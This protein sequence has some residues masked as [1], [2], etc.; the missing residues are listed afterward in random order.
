MLSDQQSHDTVD[1]RAIDVH[2]F[3]EALEEIRRTAQEE[4]SYE[5]YLHLRKIER[6]GRF[7][8]ALGVVTC[9]I[10]PNPLTAFAF[11]LGQF[12]RWLLAHHITHKGYDKVPG[13]PK[14][15]TAKHFARGWRRFVD[16]FDWLHPEAWDY[17]HNILH[18]YHT[19]EAADPDLAERHAEFLRQLKLPYSL[20]YVLLGLASLT[21]KYTYYAPN[22]LSVLDP[23]T[24]RRIA[25]DHVLY[26]TIRN[27]FQFRNR[28]VRRLWL[29]CYL[30]YAGFHFVLFPL[31]FLPFGYFAVMSAFINKVLAE[32]ITNFHSFL[33][34]GPNHTAE[35]LYRFEF[36]YEGKKEFYVTQ[37]L[38][39]ANYRCGTEFLDYMSIWLNYQI[40][41]HL[42]P[43][44]PMTKY[45]DIQPKIKEV[46]E[47]FGVPYK[48]ES[49][50]K[51]FQRMVNVCVGKTSMRRLE[52]FPE[53]DQERT[54][55]KAA[56]KAITS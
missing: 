52:Q 12:T 11:S 9:W 24:N 27:I 22:T 34:I 33:V 56:R 49:I 2:G 23:D 31:L 46:C 53:L 6:M 20:K 54:F 44:L 45:R 42:F 47:R 17:E 43:D 5:D 50:W 4:I 55:S 48:Q 28:H 39:S 21:W 51:R 38:G 19:G 40:E 36:H 18:H 29:S 26:I 1:L 35:D 15:Y 3:A 30:P 14:R 25:K 32:C 10:F 37:V 13:I 8:T 16:W 7:S 41:H